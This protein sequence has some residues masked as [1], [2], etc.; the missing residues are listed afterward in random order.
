LIKE[1]PWSGDSPFDPALDWF[2]TDRELVCR[3]LRV[4]EIRSRKDGFFERPLLE[5]DFFRADVFLGFTLVDLL[6][7]NLDITHLL[8]DQNVGSLATSRVVIG[9]KGR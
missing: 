4:E 6:A 9:E 8:G 7:I 1:V 3:E 2:L 5:V